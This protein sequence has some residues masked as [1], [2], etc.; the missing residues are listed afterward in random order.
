MVGEML[1]RSTELTDRR[2]KWAAHQKLQSLREYVQLAQ[3]P[4]YIEIYQRVSVRHSRM[5]VL[6]VDDTF[7]LSCGDSC[8]LVR[9]L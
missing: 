4:A 6:D 1:S 5:T 7:E 2:E 9:D 8:V 3:D